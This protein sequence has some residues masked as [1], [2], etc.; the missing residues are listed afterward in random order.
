MKVKIGK[1]ITDSNEEPVLLF[2]SDD[3]KR[4]ISEMGV[5]KIFMSFPVDMT[6]AEA[7]KLIKEF[8]NDVAEEE[9]A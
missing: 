9:K 8:A 6:P 3:E 5:Q 4:L 2:L 7:S 1:R